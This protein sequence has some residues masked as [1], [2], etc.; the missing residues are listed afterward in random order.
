[1]PSTVFVVIPIFNRLQFTLACLECLARQSYH[2]L[3][4]IVVDGG[5]TDE[6]VAVLRRDWP[7][8]EV[9]AGHGELWWAGATRLGI[10]RA[11]ELSSG[12]DDKV[13]LINND[14]VIEPEYVAT[15]VRVSER[16]RAAVGA[17]VVDSRDPSRVLDA[18]EFIE[19]STYR[20][21]VKT[22][23]TPGETSC[24]RVDVL[25]GRGSIVPLWM[26]R[27]AG[28]V[29]ATAFPHYIADYELFA[30]LKS[31]GCRLLVTYEARIQAHIEE[32]GIAPTDSTMSVRQAWQA[33]RARKSMLNVRDHWRFIDRHAPPGLRRRAKALVAWRS[34]SLLFF[35]TQLKYLV[36]PI[37]LAIRMV[38]IMKPLLHWWLRAAYYVTDAQCV[39]CGLDGRGLVKE[40]VLSPWAM[41]GWY[42]FAGR[43]REWWHL[44][45]ELRPLWLRAWNP[46]TKPYRWLRLQWIR[47]A[48][49][50][51]SH[52]VDTGT[53]RRIRLGLIVLEHAEWIGGTIYIQNLVSTLDRLPDRERPRV[54]ILGVANPES[55]L[56][57]SLV[58]HRCV[59]WSVM[60]SGGPPSIAIRLMRRIR[61]GC[62]ERTEAI[63]LGEMGPLDVLYPGGFSPELD[64]LPVAKLYWITDFQ[65]AHLPHLFS[66]EELARRQSGMARIAAQEGLL[67]LS[68]QAALKDFHTLFPQATV[69]PRV[70]SFCSQLHLPENAPVDPVEEYGFPRKYLYL[71]N[72]FWAHKD[73]LTAF[74]ALAELR[75]RGLALPLVCTGLE[76]D[77]RQPDHMAR[78]RDFV[79]A[80]GLAEQ[81]RFLGMVPREHQVEIFRRAAAVLQP[82]RFEGWSTVVEDTK[83]VGRPLIVSD[84]DVHR[85]Q[86]E[87]LAVSFFRVGDWEDLADVLERVW[88][89]LAPGPDHTA[90]AAAQ[91]RMER[92]QLEAGRQFLA[93]LRE[94]TV[95]HSAHSRGNTRVGAASVH[96][97]A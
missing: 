86:T 48:N 78:V 49:L 85:E 44:R 8:V 10:E 54:R 27:Q 38:Q 84:I 34:M 26:I 13:L 3:R 75:R 50:T 51:T 92:R 43:R 28:N 5:S 31:H 55:S 63:S 77:P 82:S 88:P 42:R 41:E 53:E 15:L 32:T 57:R 76:R 71:P 68:S 6:T 37:H 60:D 17:L 40:G 89:T 12:D 96:A 69:R 81:V 73:H 70:W 74:K 52:V 11:L 72:Q 46:I 19:W 65:H 14:T 1:M 56:A 61:R 30:R 64:A 87:G 45:P 66:P 21:P 35:R 79:T 47:S 4:A 29:D 83:A 39:A 16:E 18:G 22:F 93:I 33:L 62:G 20:F 25:P 2:P 58:R 94:T 7:Q 80:N 36:Y 59:E 97:S 23:V 9:I 90:E 95:L 67:V 24:D 91:V